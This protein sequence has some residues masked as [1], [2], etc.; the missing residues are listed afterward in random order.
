M[1]QLNL[2]Y[3]NSGSS[4]PEGRTALPTDDVSIWQRCGETGTTYTSLAQILADVATLIALMSS[5]NAC[6]YL[7]RS[8]TWTSAITTSIDAMKAIGASDYCSTTLISDNTWNTAIQNSA[9]FEYVDNA[10]V[11]T[12]TGYTTPEGKASASSENS[13]ASPSR[14]AWKAFD[15]V[16]DDNHQW[17]TLISTTSG[18]VQYDFPYTLTVKKYKLIP[19]TSSAGSRIKDY[20]ILGSNDGFSTY[21]ELASDTLP[22][23]S[24]TITEYNKLTSNNNSY[25]SHRLDVLST[26]GDYVGAIELQFYGRTIGGVQTW[27][28]SAGITNKTYTTL[29]EVLADS[30]TLSALMA[31]H[32]AVDYLVTAKAWAS[33]ICADSTAM[34]YIG[35]NNYAS[36]TL[37]ADETW[38]RAIV[39][40]AYKTSVCNVYVPIMTSNT[41]PSGTCSA[42]IDNTNAWKAFDGTL[43]DSA[44][45]WNAN[46]PIGDRLEYEFP[47][48]VKIFGATITN[49][50]FTN[51]YAVR[52]FT[53]KGTNDGTYVDIKNGEVKSNTSSYTEIVPFGTSVSYR[54]FGMFITSTYD[55][56]YGRVGLMQYYGRADV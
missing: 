55:P 24:T 4:V 37:L 23:T 53:I 46:T 28:R 47:T 50:N 41:T 38:F 27:L 16:V 32:N 31:D 10:K 34:S 6:D 3:I 35:L 21:S 14:L 33:T 45:C 2:Y 40:S 25:K 26:N 52:G 7:V 11:P 48:T 1:K 22:N 54:K 49:R 12:M 42:N 43:T 15:G 29:A 56:T 39:T 51:V 44:D 8:T 17:T 36:D 18:W 5:E 19:S 30:T 13:S 9:Y 20:K